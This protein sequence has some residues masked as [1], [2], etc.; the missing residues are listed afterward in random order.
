[1]ASRSVSSLDT[2]RIYKGTVPQRG[3]IRNVSIDETD[4]RAPVRVR[5]RDDELMAAI[6]EA[7]RSE[8]ADAGYSGVTYEGVARRARTSKPVLYRRYP[9]RAH[10]V[11]DALPNLH[12]Q[13]DDVVDSTSLRDDLLQV[14]GEVLENFRV[15]GI[16]NYRQLIADA[17]DTLLDSLNEQVTNLAIRTIYPALSRA[18]ARGEIGPL[19]IPH[20]AATIIGTLLRDELFFTRHAVDGTVLA[21]MLDTVYLPLVNAI[22][23]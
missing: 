20:R 14:F 16:D 15:I 5:R 9:S 4:S 17:D 12:W 22:S 10:M 11:V 19:H 7:T 21:E 8:L 13:P 6:Q 3:K 18:R 2:S 1:M 23:R